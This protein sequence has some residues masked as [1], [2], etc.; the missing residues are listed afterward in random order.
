M[1]T[2]DRL[3]KLLDYSEK[4]GVFT[5]LIAARGRVGD[6]VG[7]IDE[8]GYRRIRID[9]VVYKAHRLAFLYM[10][11]E[12]P[13]AQVDHKTG[14]RD[15]NRWS[16]LRTATHAQNCTNRRVQVNSGIKGAYKR[17][18]KWLASI[19]IDGR[20]FRLGLFDT[21]EEAGLAYA[22][23]AYDAFGDFSR[24]HW[25]DVLWS[26]RGMPWRKPQIEE[27]PLDQAA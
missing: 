25:R 10:N 4:T 6:V 3:H 18:H 8:Q 2:D 11:G 5:W 14:A 9:G 1:L 20:T 27:L 7:W 16:N 23:A 15:D 24:P 22:Y 21:R 13:T 19:R 17:N 26:I 12:W